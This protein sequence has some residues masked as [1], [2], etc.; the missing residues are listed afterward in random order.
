MH[1][2]IILSIQNFSM[3]GSQ[4]FGKR[5]NEKKKRARR[6]EKQKRREERQ[7]GGPSSFEE[8]IAYV[9]ENGRIAD[10]LPEKSGREEVRPEDVPIATPKR[11][12]SVPEM[13]TGRVEH[14]NESKG[15]GFIKDMESSEKY[16]FH[17]S[18]A[19]PDI[20]EGHI[21]AFG[22]ERGTRGDE[23]GEHNENEIE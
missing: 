3:A 1:R 11:E 2:L 4:S 13:L 10:T 18:S 15:Y 9:D 12:S 19:P 22:T 6:L 8:M 5:E 16:F 7:A 21:V 20:A 17:V 23:C 14:F